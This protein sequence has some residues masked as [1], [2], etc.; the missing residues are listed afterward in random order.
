MAAKILMTGSIMMD[1]ILQM[2]RIPHPSESLLG[3]SYSNAGGGK[4]SN[5]AVAACKAGGEVS[6]CGTLG[7]D[8][9]GEAL[10]G[11]LTDIGIDVS[12]LTLKEGANTGMAVIMLEEDGMNRLA[13]YTG[14]NNDTTPEAVDAAFEG[15]EYDALMM[16]LEIPLETNVHAFELA[17]ERGMITCLDAGPAQDYPLERFK[18]LTILSPNETETEALVGILPKDDETCIAASKILKERSDCKYVV[19]KMGD[20]G[21]FLHLK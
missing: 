3:T 18:G 1:L 10:L 13:I 5:S 2:P 9:N 8:S 12:N 19:L 6:V 7:K 4:G 21:W 11:M 20:K 14:A 17:H 15:K 16:Q